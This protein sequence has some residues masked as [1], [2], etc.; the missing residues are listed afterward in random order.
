MDPPPRSK[1]APKPRGTSGRSPTVTG[2]VAGLEF[3][4]MSRVSQV[5]RVTSQLCSWFP[6]KILV[7]NSMPKETKAFDHKT[8]TSAHLGGHGGWE[9]ARSARVPAVATVGS[10]YTPAW[11][12]TPP[13]PRLLPPAR[14]TAPASATV[15]SPGSHS[16]LHRWPRWH[17]RRPAKPLRTMASPPQSR[18]TSVTSPW[19]W[20]WERWRRLWHRWMGPLW[21]P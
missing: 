20:Q 19:R 5:L 7:L 12:Y 13:W 16:Y 18:P 6:I 15:R 4:S 21:R 10:P 8:A 14:P 1:P 3:R 9:S 17:A 11:S 2:P